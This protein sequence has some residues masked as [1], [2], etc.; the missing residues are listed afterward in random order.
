MARKHGWRR[1]RHDHRDHRLEAARPAGGLPSSVDLR[2][3]MPAVYDQGDLGSCTANAIAA[4]VEHAERRAG[5]GSETPSRLFVYYNERLAEGT[6]DEDDGAEIR[7]GIKSLSRYGFCPEAMWPYSDRSDGQ[8]APFRT[9]PT[10]ACYAAARREV[11]QDY[12]RVN[13]SG[14]SLRAALA[15]GHPVVFG[16]DVYPAF[17]S[18]R[19]ARP[20]SCPC[21]APARSRPAATPC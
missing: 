6:V 8:D 11:V 16:F 20:A 3:W 2:R 18:G 9:R 15:A 4:A 21:R 10:G 19:V 17:E 12:S 7:D 5:R 1:D 13:Q 14:A